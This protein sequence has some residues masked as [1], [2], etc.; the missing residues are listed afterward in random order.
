MSLENYG[1]YS[2]F[3]SSLFLNNA[4]YSWN[5]VMVKFGLTNFILLISL[6][7]R[8]II[9]GNCHIIYNVILAVSSMYPS[10]TI[11]G[12]YHNFLN[13]TSVK[14]TDCFPYLVTNNN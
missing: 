1:A 3:M 7:K 13:T 8:N 5:I 14:L 12:L 4:Y 6:T 11:T 9:I 2:N 10:L